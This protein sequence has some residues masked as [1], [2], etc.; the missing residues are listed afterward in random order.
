MTTAVLKRIYVGTDFESSGPKRVKNLT[1]KLSQLGGTEEEFRRNGTLCDEFKTRSLHILRTIMQ[2]IFALPFIRMDRGTDLVKNDSVG[3]QYLDDICEKIEKDY[4]KTIDKLM[5]DVNLVFEQ[6]IKSDRHLKF[7]GRNL[8]YKPE[9]IELMAS[10]LRIQLKNLQ[11]NELPVSS[12]H[13]RSRSVN[14]L[15]EIICHGENEDLIFQKLKARYENVPEYILLAKALDITLSPGVDLGSIEAELQEIELKRASENQLKYRIYKFFPS[16]EHDFD[17]EKVHHSYIAGYQFHKMITKTTSA[18]IAMRTI[19]N[20]SDAIE[21]ITYIE[22]DEA[23]TK[24][25]KQRELFKQHGKVNENGKVDEV[26]LFHGTAVASLDNILS[27]NFILDAAPIQQNSNQETRKKTMMFGKGVYFSEMPSVSL[28]YGNGLLL[29]KVLL[30]KCEVF[31]PQ[32]LAPPDIPEEFDSREVVAMDKEGVIHVV[33]SPDQIL[34]Y[35]VIQLKNQS[36]TSQ[37]VKPGLG[38]NIGTSR[39]TCHVAA[40]RVQH[41][42]SVMKLS[43]NTAPHSLSVPSTQTWNTVPLVRRSN[44]NNEEKVN[45]RTIEAA[46]TVRDNSEDTEC[47][48]GQCTVCMESLAGPASK[49]SLNLCGHK[50]HTDCL[51]SVVEHQPGRG[52]V[53]CPNCQ[54][55]HGEKTGNSP[56]DGNMMWTRQPG[57]SL[58]GYEDSGTIVIKYVISNGVQETSHPNPG[59]PFFAKSFPRHSFLPDTEKGN[60]VLR[61]LIT[62]FQRGLTFTIGRSL[63]RGEDDCVIWNGIHHKTVIKDNGSGHGYPDP[64]YLDRVIGELKQH[65]I[66]SNHMQISNTY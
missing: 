31:R 6:A 8:S 45:S 49:V 13:R 43:C 4:Y 35:A 23:M 54:L 27:S 5:N 10:Q 38:A 32:G 30:G 47:G 24:Y 3:R 34:P 57:L 9:D 59:K 17:T 39:G 29:C 11:D 28:M 53:Q 16:R 1:V 33:K 55:V 21:S 41:N 26:L 58:P 65:G 44:S 56:A 19:L 40:P 66:R 14:G 48:D 61:M 20:M 51:V 50:F 52:H 2:H 18:P 64:G 22:N 15:S 25:E 46:E 12:F 60:L 63:T 37:F 7:A 42:S 62:A 36:L